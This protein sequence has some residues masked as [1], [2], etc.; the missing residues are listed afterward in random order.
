MVVPSSWP[1]ARTCDVRSAAD[2]IVGIGVARAPVE[3]RHDRPR[4][5]DLAVAQDA[6]RARR[7]R[8]AADDEHVAVVQQRRGVA[9][10]RDL[11]ALERRRQRRRRREQR[12]LRGR[13]AEVAAAV[14][15]VV[16]RAGHRRCAAGDEHAP[17]SE[18]DRALPAGGAIARVHRRRSSRARRSPAPAPSA[19]PC[20]PS[21]TVSRRAACAGAGGCSA[22]PMFIVVSTKPPVTTMVRFVD[23]ASAGRMRRRV[24]LR[25]RRRRQ[26]HRA[27]TVIAPP[28]GEPLDE[29]AGRIGRRDLPAPQD[30][31][32][33]AE[34]GHASR[35]CAAPAA[36]RARRLERARDLDAS[37]TVGIVA[38]SGEPIQSMPP[39]T[40]MPSA[41][42][43]ARLVDA[44]R[45]AGHHRARRRVH[46]PG[47]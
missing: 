24:E 7:R 2:R 28:D 11:H 34:R 10:A 14:V 4:V 18:V 33:V 15:A 17:A 43:A 30:R 47:S 1:G 3:L 35:P 41:N 37:C 13:A 26:R 16:A 42:G 6:R 8:G 45:E 23:V 38:D 9:V 21:V 46:R 29:L 40:A 25:R 36:R 39:A 27:S 19:R 22:C 31:A 12:R 20:R 5:V 44:G 32:V